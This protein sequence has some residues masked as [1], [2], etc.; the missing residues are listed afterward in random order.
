MNWGCTCQQKIPNSLPFQWPVTVAECNGK[1]NTCEAGCGNGAQA[2]LCRNLCSGYFKCNRPGSEPSKLR[3]NAAPSTTPPS[4]SSSSIH[5][6]NPIHFFFFII[7]TI[8]VI[9]SI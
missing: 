4:S 3:L 6:V 9:I 8:N 7:N 1:E 2:D 5:T